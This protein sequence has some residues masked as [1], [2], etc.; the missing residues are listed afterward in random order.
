[1]SPVFLS[2]IHNHIH[3][4]TGIQHSQQL[5]GASAHTAGIF[6]TYGLRKGKGE[7][8]ALLLKELAL[9]LK[10]SGRGGVNESHFKPF[11]RADTGGC[12]AHSHGKVPAVG[13]CAHHS[14]PALHDGAGSPLR[15]LFRYIKTF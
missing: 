11:R 3:L 4:Q 7:E 13:K 9:L 10:I 12:K 15:V 1:M 5:Q 8:L 6:L 14:K 2:N